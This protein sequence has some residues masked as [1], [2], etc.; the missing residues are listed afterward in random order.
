MM[1]F[2]P[3]RVVATT[4]LFVMGT[5]Q[6]AAQ[7]PVAP[8]ASSV[9]APIVPSRLDVVKS[10][11]SQFPMPE[12][13]YTPIPPARPGMGVPSVLGV[14]VGAGA[15]VGT[16][17]LCG[18]QE[19]TGEGPYGTFVNGKYV[20]PGAVL[21][22]AANGGCT[23]GS[24]AGAALATTFLVRTVRLSGYKKDVAQYEKDVQSYP[25]QKAAFDRAVAQRQLSIDSAATV[26]I[27]EAD[28]KLAEYREAE[29]TR[30]A[31]AA[32]R[33]GPAPEPPY[34][35]SIVPP[36]TGLVNPDAVAVVIGNRSYARSEVP[37]VDYA[38]RDAEAVRQFLTQTFGF[39]EENIIF[40]RNAAYSTMQ[41]I[42]GSE[43][44]F[45]GQLYN[46]MDPAKPSD[47][48][49]FYSGHGAPDPGSGT[50]YL[51]PSDADPQS[52][53]LTGF[54]VKQI[55]NNL[56][57]LP[58]SS[59]TVVMDACF[60]G[61]TDRGSLLRGISPLTLRVENP[62]LAATNS[63]VLTA[64]RSTEV[65][66]WYDQEKHGL[67]TY[68]FLDQIKKTFANGV[69]D[70]VPTAKALADQVTP[71]VVRMSR[72]I[73]QREQTPQL[74]GAGVDTPLPFIK[75]P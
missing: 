35:P 22:I 62:V 43:R 37:S 71:E 54:P 34:V 46:Y 59:I 38:V 65:S 13:P 63:V 50:A 73:R 3:V 14:L 69:P 9:G 49:V 70:S 66:G 44:D 25:V 36:K 20:A 68:T 12:Q 28:R 56:A 67:F 58:A 40:E 51:V 39:R 74:F 7:A 23:A 30:I 72:R 6:V 55:Y 18:K 60:S 27:A 19:V 47:V 41:R 16:A 8:A 4:L 53:G 17:A 2:A 64:S 33:G 15:F 29:L 21:P 48:F 32:P 10:L 1:P 52:I 57:Q 11:E 42:F 26:V 61:L 75:K 31:A 5:V 45:K 24:A